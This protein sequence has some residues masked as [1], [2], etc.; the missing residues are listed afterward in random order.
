MAEPARDS[1]REQRSSPDLNPLEGAS[2]S[3]LPAAICVVDDVP[4]CVQPLQRMLGRRY[5]QSDI[6]ALRQSTETAAEIADWV[7]R[8]GATALL[9]DNNMNVDTLGVDVIAEIAKRDH[10]RVLQMTFAVITAKEDEAREG[11]QRLAP[12]LGEELLSRILILGKPFSSPELFTILDVHH[13]SLDPSLV[14][15]RGE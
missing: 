11:L 12:V 5:P 8:Q 10:T 9:T 13:S 6:F 7:L 3:R 2:L 4:G 14:R 15:P 1:A